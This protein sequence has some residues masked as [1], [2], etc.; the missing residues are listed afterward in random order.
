LLEAFGVGNF[1]VYSSPKG[2]NEVFHLSP[3]RLEVVDNV[4]GVGLNWWQGTLKHFEKSGKV[5]Y[6]LVTVSS[7]IGTSE[8]LLINLQ[9]NE[10]G[11]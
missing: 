1:D 8:I 10:L 11:P 9:L 2:L 4:L 3:H 7:S 5:D 6:R